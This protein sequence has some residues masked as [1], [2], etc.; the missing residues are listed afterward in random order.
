M[1]T[2]NFSVVQVDLFISSSLAEAFAI[3]GYA[4][5]GFPH[6]TFVL[7]WTQIVNLYYSDCRALMC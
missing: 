5:P 7:V 4:F 1:L 2:F 3:C 6:F